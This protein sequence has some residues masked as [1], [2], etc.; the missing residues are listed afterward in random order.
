MLTLNPLDAKRGSLLSASVSSD[1][2][3]DPAPRWG[4]VSQTLT[5]FL[6]IRKKIFISGVDLG[7]VN[8]SISCF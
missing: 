5:L 4:D 1:P 6:N 8:N 7:D 2:E 3:N